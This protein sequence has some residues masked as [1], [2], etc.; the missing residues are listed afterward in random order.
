MTA[1][2]GRA[3]VVDDEA[4]Q[5]EIIAAILSSAGWDVSQAGGAKTALKLLEPSP[6]D[7]ILTDLRMADEDG[8]DLLADL[9]RV[10]PAIPVVLMTAHGSV[11]TAVRAMKEGAFDYLTKPLDRA[12][13]LLTLERA[14][15]RVRLLRQNA[16]LREALDERYSDQ[17]IVAS[18]GA[19]REVMRLVAKVAPTS[20]SVLIY[21]ETGTGKEVIARAIHAR[22]RRKNG[23]FVAINCAAIPETLL[24][25]ELFGHEKGAFTGAV[26]R[27]LGHFERASQG[28]LFLD[29]IGDLPLSLQ[30]KLLRVLQER[31]ILRVGGT[32]ALPVD[33]RMVAATHSDLAKLTREGTFREDLFWRLNVFPIVLPPLRERSTDVALLVEHFLTRLSAENETSP[34]RMAPDALAALMAYRWPGNVREVQSVV[35]RASVMAD[36]DQIR[37]EDLP[38]E[39]G[40]PSG[41]VRLTPRL[42][43][44][45]P[46]DGF[47]FEDF[48]RQ[49][50][51]QAMARSGHVIAKAAKMLGMTYRT[52]QYRLEKFGLRGKDE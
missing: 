16:A 39:V 15:E 7:V 45:L 52:L 40:T 4:P 28:T 35:E 14:L 47:V 34:K 51:A 1:P 5:R 22:S 50:L 12:D 30:P 13:L 21:G 9:R 29:E 48:E 44:E 43:F 31:E 32:A 2:L 26:A 11:D 20:S 23:P 17:N 24:E 33:V 37:L 18:H 19:M 3:L 8:L 6:P 10:A 49:I 46:E 27:K 42:D 41:K 25:S 38:A 36:G